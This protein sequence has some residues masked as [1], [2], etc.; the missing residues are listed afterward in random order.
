MQWELDNI[1]WGHLSIIR[2][3]L[4]GGDAPRK[5]WEISIDALNSIQ[6]FLRGIDW[7]QSKRV[8]SEECWSHRRILEEIEQMCRS[9]RDHTLISTT[10]DHRLLQ[11]LKGTF[12]TG[13]YTV[14]AGAFRSM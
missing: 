3:L 1:I 12:K 5:A 2:R 9:E 8:L 6:E 14:D 4:A 10:Q 13:T 7:N 11:A